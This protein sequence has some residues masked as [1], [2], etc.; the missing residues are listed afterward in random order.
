MT[1][2][3]LVKLAHGQ[4]AVGRIRDEPNEGLKECKKLDTLLCAAVG[5]ASH[6]HV[7]ESR[8]ARGSCGT[9]MRSGRAVQKLPAQSWLG[10]KFELYT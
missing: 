9:V 8:T 4:T 10:K 1:L 6:Q 5:T 3:Q 7:L 2:V